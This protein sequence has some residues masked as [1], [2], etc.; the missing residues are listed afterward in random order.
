MSVAALLLM[1]LIAGN[2][3]AQPTGAGTVR[4]GAHPKVE[5]VLVELQHEQQKGTFFGRSFSQQRGIRVS[6]NYVTVFFE[7]GQSRTIKDLDTDALISLGVRVIKSSY[8]MIKADV[9]VSM[10][11]RIADSVPEINFIR[12]PDRAHPEGVM[13]EGV[14]LSKATKYHTIG[15]TGSG[16]KVAVIDTG[17]GK[18][19][20][21]IANDEL[22]ADVV[23]IDCTG[24]GCAAVTEFPSSDSEHGTAVA[25]IIHDMAP[26]AQLYLIKVSDNLDV[27]DATNYCKSNGIRVINMSLGYFNQNFYDG[28]CWNSNVVCSVQ[29]A[30]ANGILWVKSA[31]NSA[32]QHYEAV[33]KDAGFDTYQLHETFILFDTLAGDSIDLYLT[34]NAWPVT[35]QDYDM[36]LCDYELLVKEGLD[37]CLIAWSENDQQKG[38]LTPKEEIHYAAPRSGTYVVFIRKFSAASNHQL[39]LYANQF[40]YPKVS[41]SSLSSPA[42]A[43]EAFTVGA[44]SAEKWATGPQESFS[45]KGPTNDGRVKPEIAAPDRVSTYAYGARSFYG[46]SAAAPHVAGAAALILQAN[47][48]YALMDIWNVLI[49]AAKDMGPAGQDIAYGYGRL[50]LPAAAAVDLL[51]PL[52]GETIISG[53]SR[54]V[55]WKAAPAVTKFRLNY[56]LNNGLTWRAMHEE[57]YVSGTGYSWAI[58]VPKDKNNCLVKITGY[59]DFNAILGTDKSSPF[60]IVLP[61]PTGSGMQDG[62]P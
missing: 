22:P 50:K 33:F 52:G 27:V 37:G 32:K 55:T 43:A 45:S 35:N 47:P 20:S 21:A 46:S 1:I 39:E 57:P 18:F 28:K 7:L 41:K 11:I 23:K 19:D 15:Y 61:S 38:N 14:S 5:N 6:D 8:N 51:D 36:W 53:G 31:G 25:E 59:D 49:S 40:L 29:D 44:I 58:S 34:W 17:F 3:W 13:T 54:T 4:T 16:V 26:G 42:D 48:A 24:T 12:L 56:S 2:S 60:R 9:P 62:N 30:Y 10:I